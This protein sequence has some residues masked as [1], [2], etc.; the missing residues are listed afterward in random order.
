[1]TT[2]TTR[3]KA[4]RVMA[5][6]RM[7]DIDALIFDLKGKQRETLQKNVTRECEAYFDAILEHVGPVMTEVEWQDV[8]FTTSLEPPEGFWLKGESVNVWRQ[9]LLAEQKAKK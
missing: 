7:K 5:E 2:D 6:R 3:D 1:M 9:H 4:I 8:H